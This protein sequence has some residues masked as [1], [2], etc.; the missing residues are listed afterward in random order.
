MSTRPSHPHADP[1]QQAPLLDAGATAERSQAEQQRTSNSTSERSTRAYDVNIPTPAQERLATLNLNRL[2]HGMYALMMFLMILLV[3]V[4][5]SQLFRNLKKY[6]KS[7]DI[8]KISEM[9]RRGLIFD[10]NKYVLAT[11]ELTY[12]ASLQL[13]DY[14]SEELK[15]VYRMLPTLTD[16]EQKGMEKLK[17][18]INL[19]PEQRDS[20]LRLALHV[21][22]DRAKIIRERLPMV[23]LNRQY[24][25]VY[26]KGDLAGP[27]LGYMSI[28]AT[29]KDGRNG[30][31]RAYN[32]QIRADQITYLAKKDGR[33]RVFSIGK[34]PRLNKVSHSLQL[35]LDMRIQQ[36]TESQLK[37]AV[38]ASEAFGGVAV[39]M[40]PHNGDILAMAQ[41]PSYNPNRYFEYPEGFS[42]SNHAISTV[43][44]PGSTMKPLIVA[45][46]VEEG[47][48]DENTLLPCY[49]GRFKLGQ[50]VVKDDHA[51]KDEQTTLEM[52]QN[53]SNIGAIH[54]GKKLGVA[55]VYSYLMNFGF[56]SSV[57]LG[58]REEQA[59][60]L[61]NVT[62]M[63]T[64]KAE[65]K[66][67]NWTYGYGLNATPLQVIRAVS[68]IANGGYL[69][70]PRL[71]K[72][73]INEQGE[74]IEMFK[75]KSRPR[76]LNKKA[77]DIAT[78]AML[79]VTEK[80]T[81]KLARVDGYD[82]AG[83]TGTTKKYSPELKKYKKESYL[84]SFV[85]FVPAQNPRFVIYVLINDPQVGSRYGGS[86]AGPVFSKIAEEILPYLGVPPSR[87]QSG[88]KRD[89]SRPERSIPLHVERDYQ[90]WWSK[91][92]FL[93][94]HSG[95]EV[96]PNLKGL[97]LPELMSK[98]KE[99]NATVTLKGS[100]GR[101]VSQVP[102]AGEL[103]RK[104][105]FELHLERPMITEHRVSV[106]LNLPLNTEQGS[107][108][109]SDQRA[110][111]PSSLPEKTL[112]KSTPPPD[113]L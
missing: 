65:V 30:I 53:S 83:K 15:Q 84:A 86:A 59:G 112:T 42:F 12:L 9:G 43:Y 40:D 80:G 70:T 21:E 33:G 14:T 102:E 75:D 89:R 82:V 104:R 63:A 87:A 94:D 107:R 8:A 23:S 56:G 52:V 13:R 88:S 77:V 78:K 29:N 41:A 113:A 64:K 47:V 32:Q 55:R 54:V 74:E 50:H 39:V 67:Y 17:R 90:P 5:H 34:P 4:I 28:Q 97:D 101:V 16:T 7:I 25:R 71:A 6:H 45:A 95:L 72:G 26:T 3:T 76:I 36:I 57:G 60:R 44:E 49:G 111:I 103:L 37:D 48:L 99:L 51:C 66:A 58:L 38:R 98:L 108:P 92:R 106:P 46:A 19:P 1:Y 96:V 81:G 35:T 31:E 91:D 27:V 24:R 69:V 2:N 105:H 61:D 10:R 93:S 73:L 100:S 79:L 109:E 11:D 85:G 20:Y 22:A 110:P 62:K 18:M 68:V